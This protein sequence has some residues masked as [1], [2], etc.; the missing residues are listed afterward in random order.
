MICPVI[1]RVSK[2]EEYE[3]ERRYP[4]TCKP[5][6]KIGEEVKPESIIAHCEVSIGQRLIKIA[7]ELGVGAGSVEKY[8]LRKVGDRIYTGE[9]IARKGGVLG[10]GKKEIK[11]PTDGVIIEIDSNGDVIIK[12][13]P[14]PVRLVAGAAGTISRIGPESISVKTSG[15][16]VRGH[17]GNGRERDGIIKIIAQPNEFIIPQKITGDSGGKIIVGGALLE[18]ASI[19]KAL[20]IGVHGIV[21]GGMNHRDFLRL[22]VGVDVGI[23]VL[24]TEGF[25]TIPIGKDIFEILKKFEGNYGFIAGEGKSLLIP[26]KTT[27]KANK[28]QEVSWKQLAIN[29]IVRVLRPHTEDLIG[30]VESLS[31]SEETLNSGLSAEVAS[32]KFLSGKVTTVPSANLEIVES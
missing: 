6:A 12:L 25:G 15:V 10:L 21:V 22:G 19:E 32:V 28:Q 3:L 31:E 7:H 1:K 5:A 27:E 29:D 20:T 17:V 30:R 26:E 24:V 18:R 14:T 23:S 16:Q 11:S 4:G 9:I 8:L 13:S 2:N